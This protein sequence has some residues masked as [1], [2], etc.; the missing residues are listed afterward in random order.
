MILN[1]FRCEDCGT[2]NEHRYK[3]E[4]KS[5]LLCPDCGSGELN[6]LLSAPAV[7]TLNTREKVSHA[8]K[9]RTVQDHNKNK[10]D[11]L[12]RAKTKHPNFI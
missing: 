8:L 5:N 2:V 11:R 9:K 7:R 1:D 6:V 3:Y 4:N 10:G 12:E